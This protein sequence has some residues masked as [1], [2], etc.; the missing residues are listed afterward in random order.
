M[1]E[2]QTWLAHHCHSVGRGGLR[3]IEIY[4][5]GG[6]FALS[7]RFRYATFIR[8]DPGVEAASGAGQ[9]SRGLLSGAEHSLHDRLVG[10]RRSSGTPA[11]GALLANETGQT[12][13]Q[14]AEQHE[15]HHHDDKHPCQLAHASLSISRSSSLPPEI[16]RY[17]PLG[18]WPGDP[19][20]PSRVNVTVPSPS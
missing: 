8:S 11:R 4:G 19:S 15:H 14:P 16:S 9:P 5:A 3:H 13:S 1:D 18:V 17:L 20:L 6:N 10:F 2:E 12:D 7:F